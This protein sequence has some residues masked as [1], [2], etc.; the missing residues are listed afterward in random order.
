LCPMAP[1]GAGTLLSA[2]VCARIWVAPLPFGRFGAQAQESTAPLVGQIKR[3]VQRLQALRHLPRKSFFKNRGKERQGE[4]Q[5][6]KRSPAKNGGRQNQTFVPHMGQRH[7]FNQCGNF[8]H[9]AFGAGRRFALA[10][11]AGAGAGCAGFGC[12]VFT[13]APLAHAGLMFTSAPCAGGFSVARHHKPQGSGHLVA[14][15]GR[16]SDSIFPDMK[17]L[18]AAMAQVEIRMPAK[19]FRSGEIM[20]KDFCAMPDSA[21]FIAPPGLQQHSLFVFLGRKKA[22]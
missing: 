17:P 8:H 6:Q 18:I 10:D 4:S 2:G 15:E 13:V 11:G 14:A 22:G 16:M 3:H 20:N 19:Y 5:Q 12:A 21:V 1:R 9:C 7:S